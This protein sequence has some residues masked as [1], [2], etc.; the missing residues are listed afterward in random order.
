[1]ETR[2]AMIHQPHFIP[3]TPYFIRAITSDVL[4]IL[5]NVKFHKNY[6][7][8]R[9]MLIDDNNRRFWWT[10][11][12]SHKDLN[13]NINEVLVANN[14]EYK[15]MKNIINMRCSNY[16]D[17]INV[18]EK[19]FYIIENKNPMLS[20]INISL[21]DYFINIITTN[22]NLKKPKIICSS[23]IDKD[24][25][26]DNRTNHLI[27]LCT[28]Q[29]C[30]AIIMGTD[31]M[32]CH[33]LNMINKNNIKVLPAENYTDIFEPSIS[34]LNDFKKY[35]EKNLKE[36]ISQLVNKYNNIRSDLS[37]RNI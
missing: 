25:Q 27:S 33:D 13:K 34:I 28:N 35:G 18:V 26:Y 32:K 3:W 15:R 12:I 14:I 20:N 29:D 2:I 21:I 23:D 1:M 6:Y 4:I 10:L 7:Q 9:T 24:V 37:W 16:Q 36:I 17:F 22:N 19:S 8:N 30:N 31:S 11:P 5:D